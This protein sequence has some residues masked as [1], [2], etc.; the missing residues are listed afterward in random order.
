MAMYSALFKK[1]VSLCA[2]VINP[3]SH[4]G[5]LVRTFCVTEAQ[6]AGKTVRN[7]MAK[8]LRNQISQLVWIFLIPHAPITKM[9][10]KIR[11][12]EH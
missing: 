5:E 11:S 10:I 2:Q 3:P 8:Y 6:I 7:L 12:V 1:L 9:L 4:S